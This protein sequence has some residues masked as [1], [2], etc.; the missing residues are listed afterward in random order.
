MLQEHVPFEWNEKGIEEKTFIKIKRILIDPENLL[1]CPDFTKQFIL[2]TDASALGFG[3]VLGQM[4]GNKDK[5]IAYASRRTTRTEANYGSSQLEIAAVLYGIEHF[6]HYLEGAPFRLIADHAPLQQLIKL[7]DPKGII[8]RYIMRLQPYQI[9]LVI[10]PGRKHQD[11]DALS[12]T[13]HRPPHHIPY[14][15][16][17]LPQHESLMK[18]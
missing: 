11:A 10:R 4:V 12:R 16:Q 9:D 1:I 14:F 6:K 17:R 15:I 13:P 5:P 7:K 8:A 18:E 3:A 2:K